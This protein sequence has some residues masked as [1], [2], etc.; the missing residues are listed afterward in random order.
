MTAF[1]DF[2][3]APGEDLADLGG[4]AS[5]F[6]HNVAAIKL[7]KS[8]EAE[9]R[10]PSDL[11][12][13]EQQTLV[14]YSGWGDSEVLD[15]LFPDGAYR[16][17]PIHPSL[18]GTLTEEEREQVTSS[19]LNAHYT[20]IPIIRAIYDALDH[21]GIGAL[22][23]LRVLEPAAGIGHFFGAMPE[24]IAVKAERVAVEL[25]SITARILTFLYPNAKV[26][27]QGFE[28]TALPNDYFDLA[29]SNAPFGNLCQVSVECLPLSV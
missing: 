25:D 28:E 15:R 27:Q 11:T 4:P 16:Q 21:L 2:R 1:A 10:T 19:A 12:P 22:P 17:A 24:E 13:E 23:A 6:N 7:L 20:A 8:L 9:S 18:V 5:R 14:R 29:I 26:F 3:F